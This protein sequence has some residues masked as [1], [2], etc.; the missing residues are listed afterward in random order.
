MDRVRWLLVGAGDIAQRR[1]GPALAD[2]AH[3]SVAAVC[4]L[5]GARA[6]S[7]A[8]ALGAPEV[9][10]D[11]SEALARCDADVLYLATPQ[12]THV[13]MCLEA[14]EAG[15][16]FL[17]EKPLGVGGAD[18]LRLLDAARQTDR[19]T[20][21]SNYRRLSEQYKETVALIG[22]G[23]IGDLLGGWAVYS[24]SFYNPANR[25]ISKA[26][27]MS[28]IKELG[29]Y[30]ID[31]AHNIFGMP[32][33]ATAVASIINKEK[34]ND[35]EDISSV[36]LK[37]AGG[38][39][40]TILFNCGSPGTRHMY[41]VFGNRGRIFW[42]QWPPHGNGPVEV[43]TREGSRLIEAHTDENYHLPM[44]EEFVDAFLAGREP[45]CTLESA[46]K[47]EVITDAIFRS[48]DS[49]RTEPVVWEDGR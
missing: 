13:K 26:A 24:S 47:T 37:F 39:I 7:L 14:L 1:A 16:H 36:A 44:I 11:Y 9:Y 20:S 15:W 8:K 31:I 25:P 17:C 3:S 19:V 28:R 10:T 6:E 23:E 12:D 48:I 22:K 45:L 33:S 27:G 40:F 35:V 41:E 43:I 18:C 30:L 49:G 34:M 42:E 46:T 32:E 21:C 4:D 5:G 2:A 29:Y 38:Q